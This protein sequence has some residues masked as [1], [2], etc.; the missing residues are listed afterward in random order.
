M[1]GSPWQYYKLLTVVDSDP[2]Y[3]IQTEYDLSHGGCRTRDNFDEETFMGGDWKPWVDVFASKNDVDRK[4]NA[5]IGDIETSL[6][7][8]IKKYGLGGDG[9]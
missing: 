4:I 2:D 1:E 9:V 5:A 6:E 3:L 8:I 7:N